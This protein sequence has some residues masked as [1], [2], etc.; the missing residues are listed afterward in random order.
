MAASTSE[1]V[2]SC[3]SGCPQ[4][5]AHCA[6]SPSR[7]CSLSANDLR[8]LGPS[9]S[10]SPLKIFRQSASEKPPWIADVLGSSNA[11][12]GFFLSTARVISRKHGKLVNQ[13]SVRKQRTT[14]DTSMWG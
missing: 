11:M 6:T 8:P 14:V 9:R 13:F 12:I 4:P 2:G 1:T 7:S 10:N 5:A 3:S